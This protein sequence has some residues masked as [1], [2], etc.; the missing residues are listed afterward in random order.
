MN[1]LGIWGGDSGSEFLM[2][3]AWPRVADSAAA[4]K[5]LTLAG[6]EVSENGTRFVLYVLG[7]SS[8][9]AAG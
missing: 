6:G 7:L 1:A 4:S 3:A 9:G 2:V 8:S 5:C